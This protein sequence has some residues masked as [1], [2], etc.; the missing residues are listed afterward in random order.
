MMAAALM[1]PLLSSSPARA[2]TP[3][4]IVRPGAA[5]AVAPSMP[6]IFGALELRTNAARGA[7]RWPE[8]M[9]RATQERR[10]WLACDRGS[11]DCAPKLKAWRDGLAK[12]KSLT[13]WQQIVEVNRLVNSL[14]RFRDDIDRYAVVGD[15]R[16]YDAMA[17]VADK[18][19]DME[20]RH[21][22][23]DDEQEAWNWL[24]I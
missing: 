15:N 16:L 4:D 13:R 10:E 1:L 8:V 7:E 17:S 18:F 3:Q 5:A 9:A 6:G 21:F 2:V 14:V 24:H 23:L 19:M 12:A 20:I 22:S 11:K